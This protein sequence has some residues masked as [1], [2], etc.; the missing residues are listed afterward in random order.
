VHTG[1]L[2]SFHNLQLVYAPKRISYTYVGLELRTILAVLDHNNNLGRAKT[3]LTDYKYS[4]A[5][6]Q[7][8]LVEQSTPKNQKWRAD[9]VDLAVKLVQDGDLFPYDPAITEHLF[10]FDLPETI[11]AVPKPT[12][13]ELAA[14]KKFRV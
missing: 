3:G 5:T 12:R 4:K 14:K 9:L 11:A 1:D 8:K 2:E 6:K 13:E 7:W 10:P